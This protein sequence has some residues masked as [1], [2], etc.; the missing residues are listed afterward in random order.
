[1]AQHANFDVLSS[2][3]DHVLIKDLGPWTIHP[4][5]TNDAENVIALLN[6][7]GMLKGDI[8]VF[9][10]DSDKSLSEIVI[11]QG[12]FKGFRAI[13]KPEES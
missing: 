2:G 12:R 9:Y 4:T 11:H 5:V 10:I 7:W 13:L 3:P 6:S 8:R 1:M